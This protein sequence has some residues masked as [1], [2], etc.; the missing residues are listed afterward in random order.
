[1]NSLSKTFQFII[2]VFIIRSVNFLSANS[3]KLYLTGG[4]AS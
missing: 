1:M 2:I 3:V 4:I